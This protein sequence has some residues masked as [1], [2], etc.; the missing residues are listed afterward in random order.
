[1]NDQELTPTSLDPEIQAAMLLFLSLGGIEIHRG[2][3]GYGC[4]LVT[5][6]WPGREFI[7]AQET[8]TGPWTVFDVQ[9]GETIAVGET[10]QAA[11]IAAIP[12]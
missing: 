8:H 6:T 4:K 1:M 3:D 7:A 11:L 9:A 12:P 5:I 2:V 10:A